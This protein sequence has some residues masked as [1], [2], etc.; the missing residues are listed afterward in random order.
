MDA[1]FVK[2]IIDRALEQYP[3]VFVVDWS[4]SPDN[5][6]QVVVDGDRGVDLETII[7]LS[8]ALEH[9][10]QMDRDR[11]DFSISVSSPGAD[12]P[13]KLPRQYAKHVGR[14]LKVTL[15]EGEPLVGTLSR[16][17][18]RGSYWSGP[19]ANPNRW[20]RANIRC[21]TRK[22]FL[23]GTSARLVWC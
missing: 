22:A 18:D 12:A 19:P 15:H 17:D 21:C 14:E 8:R 1:E 16:S 4:L 7:A 9:D 20:A 3:E 13:L 11:E 23:T 6:I 5:D 2:G 10:P